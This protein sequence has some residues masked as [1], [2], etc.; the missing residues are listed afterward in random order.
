[1]LPD[2]QTLKPDIPVNLSKV[3]ARGIKKLVMVTK[4]KGRP[5]ILIST[6]DVFVDLKPTRK[7]INLSRSFEAIDEVIESLTA[8][9][10]RWIEELNL[11]IVETLLERHEYANKAE[12]YMVSELILRKR[13]PVSNYQTQEVVNVLCEAS[14]DRT[15]DK[16]VFIGVEVSGI[17]ACPCAQELVKAKAAEKLLAEGFSEE[18]VKKVLSAVPVATHN[19]RGKATVKVQITD[20]FKVSIEQLIDIAKAGM[21]Y[22][23]YELLKREDELAV[24]EGAHSNPVFVEDSVRIMAKT[25]VEMLKDAPDEIVV[26]F[27]Q[28]NEESIHQ[29]NV[30]AERVATIGELRKELYG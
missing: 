19:Q 24:V 30:M 2:V 12:V 3:G 10:V 17:T 13:T 18:D 9:P 22:D 25:A 11:K 15:G 6:F 14:K 26:F 28:E 23:I 21:S 29:H 5:A 8:K 4:G 27:R 7:G 1:M 16:K 20:G